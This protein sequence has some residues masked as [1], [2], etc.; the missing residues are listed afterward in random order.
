M[1]PSIEWLN[2][3]N[4]NTWKDVQ[5]LLMD[6]NSW[7][8][9][10]GQEVKPDDGV[11]AKE[12]RNFESRWDRAYSTIYLSIEKEY[13]N[14]ILDNCDPI[15]AWKKLQDHFQ[16]H[17]RARVI[18]LL[19]EFFNCRILEEEEIGLYADCLRT[20]VFQLRDAGHPLEDL[21]QAFQ[22]IRELRWRTNTYSPEMNGVSERFNSTALDAIRAMLRL[23]NK[24]N[25]K[26]KKGI[27]I[28]YA[29]QTKGYTVWIPEEEKV[30]ETCNVSFNASA[31]GEAALGLNNKSEYTP[32]ITEESESDDGKDKYSGPVPK[33]ESSTSEYNNHEAHVEVVIPRNFKEASLSPDKDKWFIAM[34]E[35]INIMSE[36]RVWELVPRPEKEKVIGNKW[37]YTIKRNEEGKFLRYKACLVAQGYQRRKGETYDEVFSPVVNFSIIRMFFTILACCFGW[38]HCVS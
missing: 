16:P 1:E 18:R 3:T 24:V 37:V 23:R 7:R 17:T 32:L 22:L 2:S 5:V 10:T 35:E 19:D 8:I 4:Y 29:M 13:R 9:I 20:I 34:K 21:H 36:R 12:K 28:G 26:A 27:M 30:I 11:S 38:S 33:G 14:L 25:M 31:N 15:V 6:R